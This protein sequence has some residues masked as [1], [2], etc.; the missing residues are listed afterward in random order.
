MEVAQVNEV[1]L[2][3]AI[4]G[5]VEPGSP[6]ARRD[7]QAEASGNVLDFGR[8]TFGASCTGTA[9]YC[10]EATKKHAL[11]RVQFGK[12]LAEFDMVKEKLAWMQAMAFAMEACTYQTAAV[13]DS[14]EGDFMLETAML[15]VFATDSLWRIVNDTFQIYG[16]M[17]YFT[18]EPCERM[19]RNARINMIGEGANDVLRAFTAVVGMRDVGLELKGVLDAFFSPLGNLTKLGRF[20]SRKL[21]SLLVAPQVPVRN[22][23]LEADA[24]ENRLSHEPRRRRR[25]KLPRI[26]QMDIVDEQ[27]QLGASPTRPPTSTSLSAYSIAWTSCSA[28]TTCHQRNSRYNSKPA[29]TSSNWPNNASNAT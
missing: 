15:K 7:R 8:A 18:D 29:A 4:G 16:G 6:V 9:K 11:T 27:L 12:P 19:I 2:D 13:I 22:A 3:Q 14:G 25:R 21:G 26:Y 10:V 5:R 23:E 28:N 1:V 24:A 20:T 17:A